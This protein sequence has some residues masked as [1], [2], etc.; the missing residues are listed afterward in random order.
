MTPL[1]RTVWSCPRTPWRYRREVRAQVWVV[2]DEDVTSDALLARYEPLLSRAE[3]AAEARFVF[4]A[5]RRRHRVTRALVRTVL[6]EEAPSVAPADWSFLVGAHG[7]PEIHPNHDLPSLHFNVSHTAGA[8]V[9]AVTHGSTVGIDVENRS[10]RGET[11]AIADRFFSPAEV[12]ALN[13]TPWSAQ[14]ERFFVLWT[15]KEAYI[16][17]RGLGLALPLDSFSFVL[18]GN[19]IALHC[20]PACND[21]DPRRWAFAVHSLTSSHTMA[22]AVDAAGEPLDVVLVRAVP[23]VRTTPMTVERIA[24]T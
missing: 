3:R 16:K 7:R 9:L 1:S 23:L 10:R 20:D 21:D 11:T 12:S 24:A 14:R 17:A 8:I 22:I 5:D 18:E 6:S 19:A 4:E 13:E 2:L 15:L